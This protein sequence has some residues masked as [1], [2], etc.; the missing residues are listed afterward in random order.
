MK[1]LVCGMHPQ[2]CLMMANSIHGM[3]H[4]LH[5]FKMTTFN[6]KIL[7][8]TSVGGDLISVYYLVTAKD[9]QHEVESQGHAEVAGKITV[10]YAEIRAS[11]IMDCLS[12]MY[13]QDDPKSLKSRLQE[14]LDYLKTEV[15]TDLPWQ[16]QI[17]SVK[18]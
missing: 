17:F 15:I 3:R 18:I 13:M 2:P 9:E 7:G 10:P 11:H 14:Q 4:Q 8:T 16:N 6:W 5:G 12:E 1:T